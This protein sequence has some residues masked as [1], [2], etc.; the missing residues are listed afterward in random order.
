MFMVLMKLKLGLYNKDIAY[1]FNVKSFVVSKVFRKW[2]PVLSHVLL[3]LIVWPKKEAS[4]HNGS[5][6]G[7]Q[8]TVYSVFEAT[9]LKIIIHNDYFLILPKVRKDCRPI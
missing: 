3:F 5:Y 1:I 8:I 7:L 2:L 6:D 9:N 4:R